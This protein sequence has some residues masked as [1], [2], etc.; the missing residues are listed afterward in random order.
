MQSLER[1]LKKTMEYRYKAKVKS[2]Y[3]ADTITVDVDLGFY[4]TMRDQ[5]MRLFGINAPEMRG[6]EKEQGTI[7]R[8]YV[9]EAILDKEIEI[10][11]IKDKKGKYGRWLC[12]VW[13]G[14]R[15]INQELID[16]ELAEVNFYD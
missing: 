1:R 7:S 5:K 16:K 11:T 2:V 15:N 13:L 9:R 6:P 8:D 4:M 10:E 12:V 14:D 3:D